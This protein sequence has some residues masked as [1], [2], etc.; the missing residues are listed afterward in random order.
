[1]DAITESVIDDNVV[2]IA[3]LEKAHIEL[4]DSWMRESEFFHRLLKP[5]YEGKADGLGL[6]DFLDAW[7]EVNP[8]IM[9]NPL[10]RKA[11]GKANRHKR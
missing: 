10:Y 6:K 5:I 3:H 2:R 7:A 8:S 4:V 1:M 11:I 9:D